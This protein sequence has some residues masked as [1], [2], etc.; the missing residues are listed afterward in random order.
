[1]SQ[2]EGWWVKS[3]VCQGRVAWGGARVSC[4]RESGLWV[5]GIVCQEEEVGYE[6]RERLTFLYI[7]QKSI[8]ITIRK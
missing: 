1:M 4:V 8:A 7:I 3:I 5:K 6:C 2:G